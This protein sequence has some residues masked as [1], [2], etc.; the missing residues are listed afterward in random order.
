MS[1][2]LLTAI[3]YFIV[4]PY[5]CVTVRAFLKY[6]RDQLQHENVMEAS[7][8]KESSD[9]RNL[10]QYMRNS[11]A[12]YSLF[13]LYPTV[14]GVVTVGVPC[15]L[16]KP[17]TE[18]VVLGQ[19]ELEVCQSRIPSID[20]SPTNRFAVI[21]IMES[22]MGVTSTMRY[23][24]QMESEVLKKLQARG[25]TTAKVDIMMIVTQGWCKALRRC[26]F[27]HYRTSC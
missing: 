23:A 11:P 22:K 15:L 21:V 16:V 26:C 7:Q 8:S 18:S 19:Q 4:D 13:R 27:D 5:A 20:T 14:W 25:Y 17:C 12:T 3:Y 1:R 2:S 10:S 6:T 9:A 24:P